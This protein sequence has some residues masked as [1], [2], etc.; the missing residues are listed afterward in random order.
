MKLD[1]NG[2]QTINDSIKI[3]N[4]YKLTKTYTMKHTQDYLDSV[5]LFKKSRTKK[6]Q[7]IR[8][9]TLGSVALIAGGTG[10][11]FEKRTKKTLEEYNSLGSKTSQEAFDTTWDLYK[12]YS[13]RR[14]LCYTF[15]VLCAAGF[16]VSIPF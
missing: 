6:I 9:I 16:A 4:D 12:K 11:Y 10:G 3:I 15:S 14:N 7:W 8:R 5:S 13:S 1:A 2:Y